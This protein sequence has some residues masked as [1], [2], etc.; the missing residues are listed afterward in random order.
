[1]ADVKDEMI[2]KIESAR[3]RLNHSIDTEAAYDIIYHYSV[4]LD[5]LLNQYISRE[6]ARKSDVEVAR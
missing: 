1:M 2:Q 5:E 3:R 6:M 4:E